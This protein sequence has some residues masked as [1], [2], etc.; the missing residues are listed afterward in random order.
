MSQILIS[1]KLETLQKSRTQNWVL[2]EEQPQFFPFSLEEK[3]I[4]Y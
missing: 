1:Q 2:R 4:Y 3:A